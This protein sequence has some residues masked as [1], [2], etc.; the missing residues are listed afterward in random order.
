MTTAPR[1]PCSS[2]LYSVHLNKHS[3][4]QKEVEYE[5]L[6]VFLLPEVLIAL[7][8]KGKVCD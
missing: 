3:S 6:R 1:L 4:L 7:V 5:T 8:T 2:Y